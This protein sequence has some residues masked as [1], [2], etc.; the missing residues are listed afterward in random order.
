M[1]WKLYIFFGNGDGAFR[2][3]VRYQPRVFVIWAVAVDINGDGKL[4][5]ALVGGASPSSRKQA[6]IALGNGNGQFEPL[7]RYDAGFSA[8][9]IVAADFNADGKL[10][11]A[12]SNP[13]DQNIGILAGRGDGTFQPVDFFGTAEQP[14]GLVA[15]DANLDGKSDIAAGCY[16]GGVCLLLNDTAAPSH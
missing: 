5:L 14:R 1:C 16:R 7:V 2:N 6:M 10:D 11:L 3:P 13:S 4:D 12:V 15:I 8:S 9:V